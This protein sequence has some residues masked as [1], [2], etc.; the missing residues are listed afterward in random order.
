MK[1]TRLV[2]ALVAG[3]LFAVGLGIGGMTQPEKVIGFLNLAGPWD[4]AL[5]G[6]MGGGMLVSFI[7]YRVV[8]RRSAPVCEASFQIPSRADITPQLVG[9]SALFGIGWGL[10]GYCP[11]PGIVSVVTGSSQAL[12]FVAAM[13]A[14]MAIYR[15]L[16][17]WIAD[18]RSVEA[19]GVSSDLRADA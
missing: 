5:M 19:C 1:T 15:L 2:T 4:P 9:G 11:G 6:V 7:G 16:S 13:V 18:K 8:R 3:L 14:G 12:L 10:G 17:P